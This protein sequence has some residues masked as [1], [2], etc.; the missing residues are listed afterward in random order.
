MRVETFHTPGG[1]RLDLRVP[2]G[3]IQIATVDGEETRVELESVDGDPEIEAEALIEARDGR[4]TIAI[5]E[6]KILFLKTAPNVRVRVSMP[7]DAELAANTVSADVDARGARLAAVD[8]RTVSGDARLERVDGNAKLKSVS[9]DLHVGDVGGEATAQTVSGD[10]EVGHVG[11]TLEVRTV[12]GDV[13]VAEVGGGVTGQTTSGDLRLRAVVQG[14][15]TLKTISGDLTVGIR[16]GSALWVD[17]KSVSGDT[18]SDL[19]LGDAPP[20]G[21]KPLVELRATAMSGDITVTRA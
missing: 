16:E 18:S 6:R 4:I 15:V 8:V 14:K 13:E 2:A 9:G 10:V 12:S 7:H 3:S 5:E 19:P 21:D 1:V 11:G 17:A 20:N